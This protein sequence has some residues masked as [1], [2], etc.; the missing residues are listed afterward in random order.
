[1]V[2]IISTVILALGIA[3]SAVYSFITY[4]SSQGAF[5]TINQYQLYI[6]LPM[7]GAYMPN[8][9]I[10]YLLGNK[11]V[12]FSFSFISINDFSIIR[13]VVE[14]LEVEQTNEYMNRIGLESGSSVVNHT[15]LLTVMLFILMM[16]LLYLP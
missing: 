12:L 13:D 11:L 15:P 10:N 5:S 8:E 4:S 7:I 14:T 6:L 1:V 9:I 2:S 16:H 3:V